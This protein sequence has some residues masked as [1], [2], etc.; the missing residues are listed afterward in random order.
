M[1]HSFIRRSRGRFSCR[2]EP[3]ECSVISQV[4]REVSELIRADLGLDEPRGSAALRVWDRESDDP[5]ARLQAEA[6]QDGAARIPHDP[7]TQRLF[8]AASDDEGTAQEFRRLCQRSLAD[9]HLG[10]LS[11][12]RAGLDAR[13]QFDDNADSTLILDHAEALEWLKGLN[14]LRLVLG[15]RLGLSSDGDFEALQLLCHNDLEAAPDE[16][17]EVAGVSYVASV[18]EFLSWLQQSLVYQMSR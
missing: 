3:E 9:S 4:A 10:A 12:M 11:V 18:Y 8:P 7:A 13:G 14:I 5:L 1:A 15:D 17:S 6:A 16:D 2:L